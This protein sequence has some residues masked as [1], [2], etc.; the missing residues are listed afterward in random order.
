MIRSLLHEIN[1][2][3]LYYVDRKNLDGSLN[4][5]TTGENEYG[6]TEAALN[7]LKFNVEF[8]HRF[9]TEV[10]GQFWHDAGKDELLSILLYDNGDFYAQRKRLKVDFNT[11]DQYWSQYTFTSAS[12][13][14]ANELVTKFLDALEA[15]RV[16]TRLGVYDKIEEIDQEYLWYDQRYNKRVGERNTMLGISDWRV[17]PDV[18]DSYPG[19]KD[20]WV[21]WRQELRSLPIFKPDHYDNNLEFLKA[22]YNLRWPIDP[23]KYWELYPDGVDSEGNAVEYLRE[24]DETQWV[25]RETTASKSL[26]ESRLMNTMSMRQSYVESGAIVTS[27]VKEIMKTLRMEDFV[28]AG[29]DYTKLYTEDELNDLQPTD[30]I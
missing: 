6:F 2:Q 19:E 3:H 15:F 23:K 26:V 17:L 10:A 21:K 25:E 7:P 18:V 28:E 16:V 27:A 1:F 24:S 14:E 8:A 29:I 4:I 22:L 30:T 11:G 5:V 12:A 13:E 20:M 9:L